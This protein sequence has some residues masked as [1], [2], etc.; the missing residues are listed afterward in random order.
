MTDGDAG[1][2]T[3]GIRVS[4]PLLF[5][6]ALA[7]GL[8]AGRIGAR[9]TYGTRMRRILGTVSIIAGVAAGAAALAEIRRVGSNP[10]PF[11]A[12]KE[13]ATDGVFR[14]SRNPAYF[15]ATSIY[16][17]VA[18]ITRSLP[19]FVALPVALALLDRF[20]V[21]KEERYLEMRFGDRYRRYRDGVARWF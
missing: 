13:L 11:A 12:T 21:D 6:G 4:P 18:L 16:I 15:G 2:A 8:G 17:G 5:G 10:S 14:F 7:L 20:V 1:G 3:A 9:A 19:A